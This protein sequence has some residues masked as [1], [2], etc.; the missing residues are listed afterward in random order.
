MLTRVEILLVQQN[1][2]SCIPHALSGLKKLETLNLESN[3]LTEIPPVLVYN[4]PPN[5]THLFF[6]SNNLRTINPCFLSIGYEELTSLDLHSCQLEHLEGALFQ[7]LSKCKN[8]ARLNLA[9]NLL[10]SLPLE[11]GDLKQLQWLNLKSNQLEKL[12]PTLCHLSNL[13]RLGLAANKLQTLPHNLFFRMLNLKKLDLR[14]NQLKYLPFSLLMLAPKNGGDILDFF[15]KEH[16]INTLDH[17]ASPNHASIQRGSLHTL[18][19]QNNHEMEN[20]TGILYTLNDGTTQVK[21]EFKSAVNTP[22]H[23]YFRYSTY[24]LMS[25]FVSVYKYIS[26]T[27]CLS[28]TKLHL[29]ARD[30]MQF[31]KSATLKETSLRSMLNHWSKDDPSFH[32]DHQ[33]EFLHKVTSS[34]SLPPLLQE[35]ILNNTK[36]CDRC[37]SWYLESRFQVGYEAHFSASV[38]VTV[39]MNVCSTECAVQTLLLIRYLS[40]VDENPPGVRDWNDGETAYGR[41]STKRSFSCLPTS[42]SIN[43]CGDDI[44]PPAIHNLGSR[45]INGRL[46]EGYRTLVFSLGDPTPSLVGFRFLPAR[47]IQLSNF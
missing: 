43:N 20:D 29:P 17:Y 42:G 44:G 23:I 11:I 21:L 9:N 10:T 46:V 2:I 38:K 35:A 19:I 45:Y 33:H 37:R 16:S 39:R 25:N 8:F 27:P 13:V 7:Y 5:L 14:D 41:P 3:L 22:P 30:M 18:L 24:T 34:G 47:V 31:M 1:H 6:S 15:F 12:P 28:T 4:P 40:V 26:A 32:F 36:L